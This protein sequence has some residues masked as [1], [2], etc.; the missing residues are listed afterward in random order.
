[1]MAQAMAAPKPLD[2]VRVKD[3]KAKPAA[4]PKQQQ[5]PQRQRVEEE[6]P[7]FGITDD[8]VPF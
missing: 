8:D 4:A 6:P 3:R 1:M 5:A 2:Y 7:D